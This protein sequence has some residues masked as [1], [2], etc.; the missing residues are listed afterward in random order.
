MAPGDTPQVRQPLA[1]LGAVVIAAQP[2]LGQT[3]HN[4]FPLGP[5]RGHN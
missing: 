3:C 2:R 5:H 4:T 1:P